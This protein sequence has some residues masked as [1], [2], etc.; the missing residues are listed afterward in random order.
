MEIDSTYIKKGLMNYFRFRRQWICAD[1][2]FSGDFLADIL[3]D[4]GNLH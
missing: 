4:T 1:E 3:V 2:V